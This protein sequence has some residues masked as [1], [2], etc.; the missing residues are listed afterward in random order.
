MS[1]IRKKLSIGIVGISLIITTFICLY[2]YKHY[3]GLKEI[4]LRQYPTA[5]NVVYHISTI[6]KSNRDYDCI[7]GWIIKKG[8]SIKQYNTQLVLYYEHDHRGY[9]LPLK[10]SIRTDV[11]KTMAIGN[12]NYDH[13]GF[14]GRVPHKYMKKNIKMGFIFNIDRKDYIVYTNSKYYYTGE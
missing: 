3:H 9:V 6:Y 7:K 2:S 5:K 10:M 13:S 1:N 4:D 8:K 11:T 14:E 12:M